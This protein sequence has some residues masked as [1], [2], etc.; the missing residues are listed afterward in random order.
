MFFKKK[1]SNYTSTTTCN[2]AVFLLI[3]IY[4]QKIYIRFYSDLF[5]ITSIK[6][7]SLIL[8]FSLQIV[9]INLCLFVFLA[10]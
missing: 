5:I 3:E 4:V 7:S 1:N 6:F 9:K 10:A 2:M 8:V